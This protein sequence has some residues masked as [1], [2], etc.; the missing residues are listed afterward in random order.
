[1]FKKILSMGQVFVVKTRVI[2][3][4]LVRFSVNYRQFV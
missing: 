1:M 3:V 2:D 4:I